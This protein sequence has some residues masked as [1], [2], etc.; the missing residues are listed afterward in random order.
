[1]WKSDGGNI[2]H[3]KLKFHG[4]NIGLEMLE[5]ARARGSLFEIVASIMNF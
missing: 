5:L 1:M 4:P 3:P 2:D